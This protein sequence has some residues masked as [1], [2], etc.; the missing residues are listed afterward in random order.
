[1]IDTVVA[2]FGSNNGRSCYLRYGIESHPFA[3]PAI[4]DGR[5][6]HLV[7]ECQIAGL[8]SKTLRFLTRDTNGKDLVFNTEMHPR[9]F[10]QLRRWKSFG[11]WFAMLW[12]A[13]SATVFK[14]PPRSSGSGPF[15]FSP[16]SQTG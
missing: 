10:V 5:L 6:W 11:G 3:I 4:S 15:P 8:F 14:K 16:T 13:T 7:K 9:D 12:S 2:N 1:M